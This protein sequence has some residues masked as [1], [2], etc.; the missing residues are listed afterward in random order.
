M[1]NRPLRAGGR[2][3]PLL[4]LAVV[5][6]GISGSVLSYFLGGLFP[7]GP[8]RSFFFGF[9]HVG[10]PNL[11]LDLEFVKVGFSLQFSISTFAVLLIAVAVY[12]WYR[13]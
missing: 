1:K 10:T 5:V 11:A 3:I 13:L 9:A 2:S 4:L 12:L 6:A 8:V 7:P